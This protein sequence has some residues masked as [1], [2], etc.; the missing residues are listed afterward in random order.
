[1]HLREERM[2]LNK[3]HNGFTLIELMVSMVIG[4]FLLGGVFTIYLSSMQTQKVVENE[5]QMMGDARFAIETIA[6]DLRHSGGYGHQNHE[7]KVQVRDEENFGVVAGQCGGG[8]SGWVAD[9]D[10][11]VFAVDDGTDYLT[12][13]MDKWT[14]GDSLEVRY[15]SALPLGT[16]E[17]DLTSNMLY[18]KSVTKYSYMFRGSNPPGDQDFIKSDGTLDPNIRYFIWRSR[19]YYIADYTDTVGDGMPSLRLVTLEPGPVVTDSVLLRGVEEFQ[20]QFGLDIPAVGDEQG[21]ESA[22]I[23]M[24]PNDVTDGGHWNKV[25]AARI[26]LVLRSEETIE[27]VEPLSTYTVAGVNRANGDKYKRIVVSTSVRLRNINTGD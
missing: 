14:Q 1:M 22:D 2:M 15:A 13:C 20:I 27:E 18:L 24:N 26:W 10:R 4:L 19:A 11:P 8:A 25:I 5:V 21:D 9:L 6:Y 17:A 23:Y 3:Q 7:G 12:S 16:V